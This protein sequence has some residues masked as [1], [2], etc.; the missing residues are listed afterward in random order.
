VPGEGE[1]CHHPAGLDDHAAQLEQAQP[2]A[3]DALRKR[4]A[5]QAGVTELVPQVLV[6]ASPALLDLAQP[7]LGAPV[8]EDPLGQ[9]ARVLLLGGGGEVH[10][11]PQRF[12]AGSPS[13]T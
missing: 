13:P 6:E 4:D 11:A 1:W 7:L 9:V 3:T 2:S 12:A 5:D 10:G 8:P